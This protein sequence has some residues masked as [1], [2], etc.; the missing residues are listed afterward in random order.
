MIV[1]W[2]AKF[3]RQDSDRQQPKAYFVKIWRERIGE[4]YVFCRQ[5]KHA[6]R[7]AIPPSQEDVDFDSFERAMNDVLE[8]FRAIGAM[9]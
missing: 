5:I 4:R 1:Y 2:Q 9:K 8:F 6:R 3:L 7:S